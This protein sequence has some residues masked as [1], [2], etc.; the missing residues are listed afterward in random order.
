VLRDADGLVVLIPEGTLKPVH[1]S[2]E[3]Q[4]IMEDVEIAL[5]DAVRVLSAQGPKALAISAGLD[6]V[7][8][9]DELGHGGVFVLVD[10]AQ[11]DHALAALEKAARDAQGCAV[12]EQGFELARLRVGR[13]RL[14]A[15]FGERS[16]P[17]E[18]GLKGLAVS[19]NKGCYLGQEV[20]CTLEHRG[21]LSRRLVRLEAIDGTVEAGDELRDAQGLAIGT[22]TSAQLDPDLDRSL[23]LGYAKLAHIEAGNELQAVRGR[24]IVRGTAGAD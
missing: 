14:G 11:R 15:D 10:T 9:C 21:R 4:I 7:F 20:V 22:I 24:V 18:A 16:Y 2:F 23:A 8:P 12:D 19:F 17:Q 3:G 13:P 5:D 1:E 6:R